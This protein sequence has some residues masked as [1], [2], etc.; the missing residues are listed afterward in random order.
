MKKIIVAFGVVALFAGTTS[1]KKDW[2]CT[3]SDSAD[4]ASFA[5]ENETKKDAESACNE[6]KRH[7]CRNCGR[8]QPRL[9]SINSQMSPHS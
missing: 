3:C 5:I 7:L 8:L 6:T 9:N 1:C 2:T 4:S